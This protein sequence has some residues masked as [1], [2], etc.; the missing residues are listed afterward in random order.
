MQC[1]RFYNSITK[2]LKKPGDPTQTFHGKSKHC[3]TLRERGIGVPRERILTEGRRTLGMEEGECRHKNQRGRKGVRR[4]V[5]GSRPSLG[6]TRRSG[7]RQQENLDSNVLLQA[8]EA[9]TKV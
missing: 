6:H 2:T 4:T 8:E 1:D 9:D 7:K 3:R 5:E